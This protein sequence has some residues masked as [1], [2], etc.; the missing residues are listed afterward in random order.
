MPKLALDPCNN[1]YMYDYVCLL[2]TFVEKAGMF[3]FSYSTV[4]IKYFASNSMSDILPH[5]IIL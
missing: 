5:Y 2:F 4:L 1:D 3:C